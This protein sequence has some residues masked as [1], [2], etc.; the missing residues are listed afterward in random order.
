M[1]KRLIEIE[2][3]VDCRRHNQSGE[4]VDE[5]CRCLDCVEDLLE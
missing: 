3:D 4:L 1:S 2:V 5:S